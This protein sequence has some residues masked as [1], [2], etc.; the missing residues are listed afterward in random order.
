M[1]NGLLVLALAAACGGH[2]YYSGPAQAPAQ[3][4]APQPEQAAQ[5]LTCSGGA[6]VQNDQCVCP[7][8]TQWIDNQCA[9]P[10]SNGGYPAGTSLADDGMCYCPQGESWD[11]AKCQTVAQQPT[12][13]AGTTLAE[14]GQ[15]YCA[16][17]ETWDGSQC[18]Q[19]AASPPPADD[20]GY[21]SGGGSSGDTTITY[22]HT[23]VPETPDPGPPVNAIYHAT[24]QADA[25]HDQSSCQVFDTGNRQDESAPDIGQCSSFCT[26]YLLQSLK[27]SC[28]MGGC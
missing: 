25:D 23:D 21:T 14:D 28:D 2:T 11:G 20:S 19:M 15:C 22:T 12:C 4:P 8:G 3:D 24:F 5:P 7:G 13:P 17:G 1:R 9:W 6:I 10:A 18:V 16:Q 27:C 26:A